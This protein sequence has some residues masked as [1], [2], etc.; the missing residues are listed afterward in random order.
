MIIMRCRF[1]KYVTLIL[2]AAASGVHLSCDKVSTLSD[3][4]VILSAEVKS[5]FPVGL[6]FDTP[7][8]E[9]E[10]IILPLRFGK[11]LFPAKINLD[12]KTAGKI[13]AI[14][15]PDDEGFLSFDSPANIRYIYVVS[16]SG[17]T[18]KYQVSVR[19]LPSGDLAEIEE[20]NSYI[21]SGTD[22]SS[23]ASYIDPVKSEVT[24]YTHK[25]NFP[26]SLVPD[27]K[28]SPGAT[29]SGYTA[30]TKFNFN[31]P[32][33]F[34]TLQVISESGRLQNWKIFLKIIIPAENNFE[35]V[36]EEVKIRLNNAVKAISPSVIDRK[37]VV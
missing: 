34:T 12:F 28:L 25:T 3:S 21:V 22:T 15:G 24:I 4:N 20:L 8:I 33:S 16:E 18:K 17:L 32:G 31:E 14:L 36:P 27:I 5:S 11:Y 10:K 7:V 13:P 2:L 9:G 1:A 23:V 29:F 30:G 37:S 26:L 6:Q 19:I 35:G